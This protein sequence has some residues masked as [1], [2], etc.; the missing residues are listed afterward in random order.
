MS[1]LKRVLIQSLI[2]SFGMRTGYFLQGFNGM[3]KII[4]DVKSV[5][6]FISQ[7]ANSTQNQITQKENVGFFLTFSCCQVQIFGVIII[8]NIPGT[9]FLID[10]VNLSYS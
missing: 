10:I 6:I 3:M 1:L 2:N 7:G 4:Y 5:Y 9:I 8:H